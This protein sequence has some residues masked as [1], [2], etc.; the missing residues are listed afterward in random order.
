MNTSQVALRSLIAKLLESIGDAPSREGHLPICCLG[1]M[2]TEYSYSPA[3][4]FHNLY[5]SKNTSGSYILLF[6]GELDGVSTT[7][8]NAD[9]KRFTQLDFPIEDLDAISVALSAAVALQLGDGDDS[10]SSVF[11]QDLQFLLR[12]SLLPSKNSNRAVGLYGELE[13]I[14]KLESSLG[15]DA[16]QHWAPLTGKWDI[17]IGDTA[18][19]IKSTR[20][21][22]HSHELRHDQIIRSDSTRLVL[23]SCRISESDTGTSLREIIQKFETVAITKGYRNAKRRIAEAREI[24]SD[25]DL[26]TKYRV[27]EIIFVEASHLPPFPEFDSFYSQVKYRVDLGKLQG[28]E[29]ATLFDI[30][31]T[32]FLEALGWFH[33]SYGEVLRLVDL[34]KV[35]LR[36]WKFFLATQAKG[37]YKP[38]G[39]DRA[40]SIR[41][42]LS[43]DYADDK[44]VH[45]IDGTW[46][47]V[48]E[49]ETGVVGKSTT[50][51]LQ[52]NMSTSTPIGVLFE[53]APNTGDYKC[54]GLGIV[55]DYSHGKFTIEGPVSVGTKR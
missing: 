13:V 44:V 24:L 9:G 12:D 49:A 35:E 55:S 34:K 8:Q 40:L 6:D 54:L 26:E 52:N 38:R 29:I 28:F 32:G 41:V 4:W 42:T 18:I 31:N 27:D 46:K 17:V 43:S 47:L 7:I 5:M 51:A 50:Q 20:R 33:K 48:Y 25:N 16:L 45:N 53:V 30:G 15:M 10:D 1:T 21:N 2:L 37:I 14:E 11:V 22:T 36:N 3:V 39:F 23:A 19:E